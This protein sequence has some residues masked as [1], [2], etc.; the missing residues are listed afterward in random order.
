METRMSA[1][2]THADRHDRNALTHGSSCSPTQLV[3]CIPPIDVDQTAPHDVEH[4]AN[5]TPRGHTTRPSPLSARQRY[6][7]AIHSR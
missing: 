5:A 6:Y 3:S 7:R 1:N 4:S 2:R